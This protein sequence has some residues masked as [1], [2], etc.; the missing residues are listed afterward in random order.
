M[1][2]IRKESLIVAL[3]KF[4]QELKDLGA[5]ESEIKEMMAEFK[6]WFEQSL[7][8]DLASNRVMDKYFGKSMSKK[9]HFKESWRA[10]KG[11]L[12]FFG[13]PETDKIRRYIDTQL[14]NGENPADVY[15]ALAVLGAEQMGIDES[16]KMLI[17]IKEMI[18]EEYKKIEDKGLLAWKR[19]G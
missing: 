17:K 1:N 7:D 9:N 16:T 15:N 8:Y 4:Y 6:K 11:F 12:G 5:S 18:E 14:L 19:N 10:E 13:T 3:N 2:E